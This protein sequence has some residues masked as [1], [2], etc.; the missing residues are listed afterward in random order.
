MI[1]ILWRSNV[2]IMKLLTDIVHLFAYNTTVNRIMHG[3]NKTSNN[4][5]IYFISFIWP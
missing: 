3:L 1:C 5:T 4:N 2:L